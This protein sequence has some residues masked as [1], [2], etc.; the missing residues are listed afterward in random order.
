M[1]RLASLMLILLAFV[2][3][4]CV[5]YQEGERG[6]SVLPG[7]ADTN[8]VYIGRTAEGLAARAF[9]GMIDDARTMIPFTMTR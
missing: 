5:G 3:V 9:L 7:A 8:P 1:R 6:G 4:Y 2:T